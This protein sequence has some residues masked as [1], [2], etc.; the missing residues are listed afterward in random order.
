MHKYKQIGGR[1]AQCRNVGEDHREE[2]ERPE[3]YYCATDRV[4]Q[5]GTG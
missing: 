2:R 3:L 1:M 4:A 5:A